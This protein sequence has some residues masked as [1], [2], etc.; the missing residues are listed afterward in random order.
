M[1]RASRQSRS[2]TVR[3]LK[4]NAS[5]IRRRHQEMEYNARRIRGANHSE[6]RGKYGPKLSFR[7]DDS[8]DEKGVGGFD[9]H[10]DGARS[11]HQ[12]YVP[13]KRTSS[14]SNCR[15][16]GN[17]GRACIVHSKMMTLRVSAPWKQQQQVHSHLE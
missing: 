6:G 8:D 5:A 11:G 14:T 17:R 13:N 7:D 10:G 2:H 3:A 15:C 1:D 12:E 9:A 16:R 4:M